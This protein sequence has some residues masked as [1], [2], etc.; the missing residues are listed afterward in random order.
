MAC[1]RIKSGA[2]PSIAIAAYFETPLIYQLIYHWPK[3][4]APRWITFYWN[5][6]SALITV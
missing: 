2:A 1:P 6:F 5:S 3:F 4:D